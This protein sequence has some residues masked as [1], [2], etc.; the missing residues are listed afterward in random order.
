MKNNL[1]SIT[2]MLIA[3]CYAGIMRPA[4]GEEPP[5]A[6]SLVPGTDTTGLPKSSPE[7]S[8]AGAPAAAP[9]T[10]EATGIVPLVPR[11]SEIPEW[12]D[13]HG[14]QVLEH[15]EKLQDIKNDE[16]E[17]EAEV[18]LRALEWGVEKSPDPNVRA[19]FQTHRSRIKGMLDA[20]TV[21]PK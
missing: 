15:A 2:S 10:T 17:D 12:D 1:K 4:F 18:T 16:D 9:T 8:V 14:R 20:Y 3:A 6:P 7:T 21:K 19:I 11:V 5:V 13:D